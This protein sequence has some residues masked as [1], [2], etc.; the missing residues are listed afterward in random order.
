MLAEE[1]CSDDTR[2]FMARPPL[3]PGRARA[4]CASST[5][6]A[7]AGAGIP[8]VGNHKVP[9]SND[10][11]IDA[12]PTT[13]ARLSHNILWNLAGRAHNVFT[14][15]SSSTSKRLFPRGAVTRNM[16]S[17]TPLG[18][19]SSCKHASRTCFLERLMITWVP[20]I[21]PARC[22]AIGRQE[23]QCESPVL[24]IQG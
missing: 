20:P 17:E 22:R 21:T 13:P 12:L 14:P 9:C 11:G 3:S 18:V 24:E 2:H 4:T 23:A 5:G 16:T 6:G 7:A 8:F 15:L 19:G 1:H 10:D